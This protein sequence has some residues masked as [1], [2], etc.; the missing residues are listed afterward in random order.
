MRMIRCLAK[1][2]VGLVVFS[3]LPLLAWGLGDLRG[4]LGEPV[5]LAYLALAG[6]MAAVRLW[7]IR[8][9]KAMMAREYGGEWW[10]YAL[11]T[12]RLLPGIF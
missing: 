1:I 10:E 9:E 11:R 6:A 4:F 5:R 2:I 12:Q 8:A 3:G 7:R